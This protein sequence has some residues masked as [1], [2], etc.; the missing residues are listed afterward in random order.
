MPGL[1]LCQ[2]DLSPLRSPRHDGVLSM[3]LGDSAAMSPFVLR[4]PYEIIEIL[5]PLF[6]TGGCLGFLIIVDIL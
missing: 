1:C 5:V 2:Q 6:L 4:Q 3:W